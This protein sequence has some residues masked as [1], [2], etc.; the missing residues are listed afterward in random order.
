MNS[1][2]IK[3]EKHYN[4]RFQMIKNYSPFVHL[5]FGHHFGLNHGPAG[6]GNHQ[7]G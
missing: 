2:I 4:E 6:F 1:T 3:L 7:N 5:L